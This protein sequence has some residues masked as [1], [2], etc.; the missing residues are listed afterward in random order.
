MKR[1]LV[2][3][4]LLSVVPFDARTAIAATTQID[5]PHRTWQAHWITH[6]TAPLRDPLVLH[7]RRS[8]TLATVPGT[9]EVRVSAD[10]RLILYVSGRRAGDGPARGGLGHWRYE[11][12]DLS[13]LLKTGENLI[14]GTVWN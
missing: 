13:P 8:L 12:F 5:P 6:P 7:F 9:Y 1:V 3:F 4:V 11:R 14:T 10:N 2:L